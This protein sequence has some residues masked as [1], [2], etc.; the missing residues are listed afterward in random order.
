MHSSE[1]GLTGKLKNRCDSGPKK[2]TRPALS[3]G[4]DSRIDM[5]II[6]QNRQAADVS[7]YLHNCLSSALGASSSSYLE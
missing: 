4:P 5:K 7:Y 6:L 3:A 2:E 1:K